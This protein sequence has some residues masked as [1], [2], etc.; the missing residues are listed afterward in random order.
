M[1]IKYGNQRTENACEECTAYQPFAGLPTKRRDS[2]FPRDEIHSGRI[3]VT[4]SS[5]FWISFVWPD[6][7]GTWNGPRNAAAW[8]LSGS[9][10]TA[11]MDIPSWYADLCWNIHVLAEYFL[12]CLS[13]QT[14][15]IKDMPVPAPPGQYLHRSILLLTFDSL[16]PYQTRPFD[17]LYLPSSWSSQHPSSQLPS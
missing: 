7:F 13:K 11:K 12:F 9:R 3:W 10:D 17:T 4:W 16:H 14:G 5:P 2:D 6:R 8:M 15:S 1:V